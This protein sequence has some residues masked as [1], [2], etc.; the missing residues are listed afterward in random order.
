[1]KKIITSGLV[2]RP[3]TDKILNSRISNNFQTP[4]NNMISRLVAE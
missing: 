1:M 2:F 4:N 3:I